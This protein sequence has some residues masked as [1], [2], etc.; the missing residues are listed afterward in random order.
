MGG[1]GGG[2]IVGVATP[3]RLIE[4]VEAGRDAY[5]FAEAVR[6]GRGVL[7][8]ANDSIS[9]STRPEPEAD[10]IEEPYEPYEPAEEPYEPVEETYKEPSEETYECTGWAASG[11]SNKPYMDFR[12][13]TD[14]SSTQYALIQQAVIEPDG[15]LTIDGYTLVA[16]GH[17][18][19]YVGEKMIAIIGGREVP[20]IKADEKQNI[21]T[22]NG[23]GWYGMNGHV[24]E[25]IVDTNT[26]EEMA[27]VMGDCDYLS[28]MNGP[29]T[30]IIK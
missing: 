9:S 4:S 14:T 12:A 24:L 5:T 16:M 10:V 21:H 29:V 18:W 11:S 1:N 15:R 22:L 25:C 6:V 28:Y 30:E 19:G 7:P 23:E 17:N 3:S 2:S 13:V 8:F 20:I 26:L 27:L